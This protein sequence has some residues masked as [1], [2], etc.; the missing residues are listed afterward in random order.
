M[1]RNR[2]RGNTAA[3]LGQAAEDRALAHLRG[4]GLRLLTRNFRCRL[5]ELDL[6]MLD[7]EMLV[8]V[9]V[10]SRR[11]GRFGD[12][13]ASVTP[14]KQRRLRAAAAY[15]LALQPQARAR[16]TRFDLV[17]IDTTASAD[18]GLQWER[19]IEIGE[20]AW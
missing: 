14:A 17:A 9:E 11:P 6:V 18:A 16:L 3:A 1:D 8:F 4:A 2:P 20:G 5:G 10:R 12:A 13:L 15:Y 19:G 7:G